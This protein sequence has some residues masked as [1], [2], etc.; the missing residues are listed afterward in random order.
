LNTKLPLYITTP[1]CYKCKKVSEHLNSLNIKVQEV[2]GLDKDNTHYLEEYNLT[3]A[4]SMIL[5]GG[6]VLHGDE[7]I[8]NHFK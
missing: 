7:E 8:L 5:E 6:V 1:Y 3:K 4:P 2:N